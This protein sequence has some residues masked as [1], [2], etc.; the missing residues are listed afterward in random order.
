MRATALLRRNCIKSLVLLLD[1]RLRCVPYKLQNVVFDYEK[2][3][4]MISTGNL[5]RG[6]IRKCRVFLCN[7]RHRTHCGACWLSLS[8]SLS[9]LTG[10]AMRWW[11]WWR[12]SECHVIALMTCAWEYLV[13]IAAPLQTVAMSNW[14]RELMWGNKLLDARMCGARWVMQHN[15]V[16]LKG[17]NVRSRDTS[18]CWSNAKFVIFGLYSVKIHR[19]TAYFCQLSL[20]SCKNQF[21]CA[22]SHLRCQSMLNASLLRNNREM[23]L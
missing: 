21:P 2:L 6:C 19:D 15:Y 20:F 14:G 12:R 13:L 17:T 10:I 23:R 5:T 3:R 22:L 4:N 11:W 1:F 16:V 8:L 18:N 9:P 7:N